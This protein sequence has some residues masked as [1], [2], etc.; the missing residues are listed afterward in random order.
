MPQFVVI[1]RDANDEE[2]LERRTVTRPFHLELAKKM[3]AAGQ[4]IL[5]GALLDDQEKM[6]GSVMVVEFE[7]EELLQEWLAIEPYIKNKVWKDI[8]VKPFKVANI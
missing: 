5:G 6:R 4:L 3:K 8:E 1:A 2:A 7:T